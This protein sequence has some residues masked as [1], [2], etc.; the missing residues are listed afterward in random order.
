MFMNPSWCYLC[1]SLCYDWQVSIKIYLL[2]ETFGPC[3]TLFGFIDFSPTDISDN[4]ANSKGDSAQ[5]GQIIQ[6]TVFA[7]C[8]NF[9]LNI[10]ITFL[11]FEE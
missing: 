11:E 1:V 8:H 6:E 3:L 5:T 4:S 10:E 2:I 7:M 9:H